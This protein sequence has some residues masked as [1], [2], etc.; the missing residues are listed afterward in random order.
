MSQVYHSFHLFGDFLFEL[1][2]ITEFNIIAITQTCREKQTQKHVNMQAVKRTYKQSTNK[3]KL[4]QTSQYKTSQHSQT[5]Q[6]T[7]TT[8]I[9][10]NKLTNNTHTNPQTNKQAHM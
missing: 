8:Y 1:L 10:T 5:S 2:F 7:Q 6:H 9:Q 4:L 3:P